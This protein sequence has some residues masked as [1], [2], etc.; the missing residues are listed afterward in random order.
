MIIILKILLI[1]ALFSIMGLLI[2][3][4]YS[5]NVPKDPNYVEAVS[6]AK[7][8]KKL[9]DQKTDLTE[10]EKT[11]AKRKCAIESTAKIVGN[12][13]RSVTRLQELQLKNLVQCETWYDNYKVVIDVESF[14]VLKP[15]QLVDD[16]IV[17]YNDEIW[18]YSEKDRSQKLLE[19][20]DELGL[21]KIAKIK[22]KIPQAGLPPLKQLEFGIPKTHVDC[23]QDYVLVYKISTRTP[24]CISLESVDKLI[25]R[26][27]ASLRLPN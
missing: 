19:K 20:A 1:V 27:W 12:I 7:E 13:E 8:C 10:A 16:C 2:P 21:F 17:L 25:S 4:A 23:K 15:R 24:A 5:Q 22:A 11:V 26:G 3:A 14:K 18:S 6:V 9:V